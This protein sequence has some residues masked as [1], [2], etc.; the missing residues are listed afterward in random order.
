M[1][2]KY[3]YKLSYGFISI[4]IHEFK[5]KK[6]FSSFMNINTHLLPTSNQV[7]TRPF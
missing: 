7:G 3:D 1:T 5:Y 4:S 6:A 2:K